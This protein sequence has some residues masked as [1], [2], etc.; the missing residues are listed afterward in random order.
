MI[1][2][3]IGQKVD[4]RQDFLENGLRV[5]V[6]EIA[7]TDNVVLQVKTI[8][9]DSYSAVQLGAGQKKKPNKAYAGHAK[10]AGIENAPLTIKEVL[11]SDSDA[12]S[13]GDILSVEAIFQPG[14]LVEITA[15]SKGKGFA[16]GIKRY[17]FKGGPKTHGQSDRHRAPGSI[18]QTTTP[19]RVYKG[20]RMA[21]R[22]GSD[23]VT[24]K[25]LTVVD[26][27]SENN[28]LYVTGLVP[29]FKKAW[30]VVTKI[31]ENNKFAQLLS[32]K[33]REEKVS[34]EAQVEESQASEPQDDAKEEVKVEDAK[35]TKEDT[36][37]AVETIEETVKT[38][39]ET[40][41]TA[42]EKIEAPGEDVQDSEEKKD[43]KV[44][45]ADSSS[46]PEEE[47]AS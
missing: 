21:G 23:T 6:T 39:D 42:E 13:A 1:N 16:S 40:V 31:G 26:V 10:K 5:P 28:K 12:P 37:E 30:I 2:T 17:N 3:L 14:D 25:N 11:V 19:G 15:T 41:D 46:G 4:Q 24:V 27:D 34:E 22:M 47:N 32:V 44:A 35:A 45:S 7:V 43:A 36:V 9:K 20:K 8:E 29:G 18:G 33:S 38:S